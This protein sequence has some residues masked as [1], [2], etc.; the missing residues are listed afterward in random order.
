VKRRFHSSF[1]CFCINRF[2]C[3][4]EDTHVLLSIH[5]TRGE[6]QFIPTLSNSSSCQFTPFHIMVHVDIEADPPPHVASTAT[7][8]T[9]TSTVFH[10]CRTP[11]SKN[12]KPYELNQGSLQLWIVLPMSNNC[13]IEFAVVGHFADWNWVN[14][15]KKPI[16]SA[17]YEPI[18]IKKKMEKK[19]YKKKMEVKNGVFQFLLIRRF[20]WTWRRKLNN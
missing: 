6:C 10:R 8:R 11:H 2:F 14:K 15:L 5:F 20:G 4:N 18:W 1:P 16:T 3:S 9:T 7:H 12:S 17:T 19:I 13:E